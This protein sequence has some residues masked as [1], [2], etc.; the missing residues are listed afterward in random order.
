MPLQKPCRIGFLFT[1]GTIY[2]TYFLCR[3]QWKRNAFKSDM[4]HNYRMGFC[5]PKTALVYAD[6]VA[7]QFVCQHEA[8]P[9]IAL[10]INIVMQLVMSC[11]Q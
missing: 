8:L 7:E 6:Y 5:A 9:G 1:V 11:N 2:L 10:M 3:F 4:S